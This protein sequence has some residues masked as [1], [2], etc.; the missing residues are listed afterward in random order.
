MWALVAKMLVAALAHT[1]DVAGL[2]SAVESEIA[3]VA[4][5]EGGT[6]KVQNAAAATAALSVSV[7]KIAADA[8]AATA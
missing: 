6:K 3:S 2:V 5:G 4:T 1:D 8:A 7:G